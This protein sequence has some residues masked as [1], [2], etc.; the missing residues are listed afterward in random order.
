MEQPT[1]KKTE[2]ESGHKLRT[3]VIIFIACVC[4]WFVMELE[5]LGVRALTPHFGSA[6][7]VV[8]GSVIGVF[9][10][11]LSVGYM[12]GGWLSRKANSAR[13]LGLNLMAAGAWLCVIP[14][15]TEPVCDWM[16]NVGLDEKW[17]SL[18]ASLVLFGLP[19]AL[20]GTVSPIAARWLTTQVRDSGFNAGLVLA[21]STAASFVGCIVTAFY[22]V[23]VSLR[24]TLY[25]S[26][27]V[28]LVLGGVII[29]QKAKQ[30]TILNLVFLTAAFWHLSF[31]GEAEAS[32]FGRL[33]HH[34]NSLYHSIFVYQQGPV[35]TLR[36]G[37]Q[38]G[39]TI[40]SQVN[41]SNLREHKLEYTGLSFCGLLYKPQ[42]KKVLVLG[43]GGGVIPRE[44]HYY[45]PSA[46]V[47]V[48]EIDDE[49]SKIAERFFN[50]HQDDK[51]RVNIA[52]GRMFIKEQLRL[53]PSPKYDIIILDAFNGDYIPFH[54]MTREFLE[55]VKG[56]LAE[57][58]VVVA[59]VFY[60][61]RLFDAE[62][63]TFLDVFGRCQVFFGAYSTNA[64][65]IAPGPAAPTLTT[66]Q[67][68]SRAE[69]LQHKHRFDFNMLMVA[70]R[71]QP[72]TRPDPRAKVLTD[73]RA[74]VN[75][76]RTQE[77]RKSSR[78]P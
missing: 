31:A 19:T 45:F 49:I 35:V 54:L 70:K 16:F 61:N 77:N 15:L 3:A 64:M 69:V 43:L 1:Y 55:E 20:L 48:V 41:L 27:A 21:L 72:N 34:Q 4:G 6:V 18:L 26:G 14:F 57:D 46:D 44:M 7:Y 52:D 50:F 36:F 53:D 28:L 25:I 73:D 40:Q 60:S 47:N 67:A 59:N 56:V 9:L 24:Y 75:R 65:L 62:L 78:R 30:K 2:R 66:E 63:A 17:G 22:L 38:A 32:D 33:I 51:L 42:P 10:L 13:V 8:T 29:L 74:P 71:L 12:L 39:V 58:G 68:I 11:S 37:R 23:L 5:I 76:L